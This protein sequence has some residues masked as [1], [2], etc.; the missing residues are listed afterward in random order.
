MCKYMK[1]KIYNTKKNCRNCEDISFSTVFNVSHK[2]IIYYRE[3]HIK[4]NASSHGHRTFDKV[5][6]Y[7]IYYA[8]QHKQTSTRLCTIWCDFPRT[9][10]SMLPRPRLAAPYVSNAPSSG[11]HHHSIAHGG[12]S[13]P[14]AIYRG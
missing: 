1:N 4:S 14:L 3:K 2:Y 13:Y 12:S 5:H 8:K 10:L 7:V 6:T 11:P 9:L